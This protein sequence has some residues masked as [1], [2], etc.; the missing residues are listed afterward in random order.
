MFVAGVWRHLSPKPDS[1]VSFW[2]SM[3][4]VRIR[5]WI[6][7]AGGWWWRHHLCPSVGCFTLGGRWRWQLFWSEYKMTTIGRI[8]L[9][10]EPSP[11]KPRQLTST[12]RWC[13]YLKARL[14]KAAHTSTVSYNHVNL[15]RCTFNKVNLPVKLTINAVFVCLFYVCVVCIC[16]RVRV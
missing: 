4:A 2:S 9:D 15:Q 5:C 3:A 10:Q 11:D 14:M 1:S 12:L 7:A 8:Q 13:T 16:A 6:W